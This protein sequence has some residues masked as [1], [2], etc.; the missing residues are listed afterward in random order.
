MK[1][2]IPKKDKSRTCNLNLTESTVKK[3]DFLMKEYECE[4]R[5]SFIRHIINE[6]YKYKTGVESNEIPAKVME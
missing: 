1:I 5:S 3:M 2:L 6:I 4:S